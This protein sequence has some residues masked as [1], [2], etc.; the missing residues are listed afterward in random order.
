MAEPDG[1]WDHTGFAT[2][3]ELGLGA[4]AGFGSADCCGSNRSVQRMRTVRVSLPRGRYLSELGEE[5]G[6]RGIVVPRVW[7]VRGGMPSRRGAD[8][9]SGTLAPPLMR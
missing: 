3:V 9:R 7:R 1:T 6:R 5:G 8:E 2:L 4:C